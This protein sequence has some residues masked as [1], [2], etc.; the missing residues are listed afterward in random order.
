M[1]GLL[2]RA[3]PLAI[4]TLVLTLVPARAT[5]LREVRAESPGRPNP[6]LLAYSNPFDVAREAA[7]RRVIVLNADQWPLVKR[8]KAVN[9]N[10][11]VLV[12]KDLSSAR[13]YTA[14]DEFPPTGVHWEDAQA[15]PDWFLTDG[16]GKRFEWDGYEDHW[17]MDV[18]NLQYR[19]TWIGR[20]LPELVRNGWDGVFLDNA[21]I[22]AEAYHAG[23][24]PAKYPDDQS[25]QRVNREM[26]EA[27]ATPIRAAGFTTVVNISNSRLHPGLWSD[28]MSLVDGVFEEHFVRGGDD[29]ELM[30]DWGPDGWKAHI[31][32]ITAATAQGKVAMVRTHGAPHD[33]AAF[34]YGLAS[35]LL[36]A[37]GKAMYSFGDDEWRSGYDLDLG[38]P[39]GSYR[40]IGAGV[41]RRDF[42]AGTVVVNA[43]RA[44]ATIPWRTGP[45]TLADQHAVIL[46]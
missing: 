25:F 35:Y 2:R 14:G 9:P 37:D 46:R 5:L 12:Y 15:H 36:A 34:L 22:E 1:G 4:L 13:G 29:V 23:R 20:V 44:T 30:W 8:I 17:Q 3:V 27:V 10:C 31:D 32:E 24:V 28:W 40:S 21:L 18:G 11:Q 42:T 16:A 26:L 19:A 7:R 45:V 38:D 6:F 41:Y 43:S 39:T 33:D